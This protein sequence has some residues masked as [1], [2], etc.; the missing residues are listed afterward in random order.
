[1]ARCFNEPAITRLRAAMG[2]NIAGKNRASI[3]PDGNVTT[4][5]GSQG[6]GEYLSA[7]LHRCS[8]GCCR[9][10]RAMEI[11]TNKNRPAADR[12]GSIQQ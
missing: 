7:G 3:A 8:Q 2:R 10:A 1:M 9:R 5:A 12:A 6:I 4:I 11:T